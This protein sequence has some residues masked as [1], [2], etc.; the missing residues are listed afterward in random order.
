MPLRR[1]RGQSDI[2]QRDNDLLGGH[3]LLVHVHGFLDVLEALAHNQRLGRSN[4]LAL[5]EGSRQVVFVDGAA[6]LVR[7]EVAA[8]DEL[9]VH[10]VHPGFD[11][12]GH[13]RPSHGQP[14]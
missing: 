7:H 3:T 11:R 1:E 9:C 4:V 2:S 12:H 5:G 13:V 6:D 10:T 14:G 8:E